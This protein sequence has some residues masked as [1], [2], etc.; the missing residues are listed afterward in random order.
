MTNWGFPLSLDIWLAG[1]AGGAY[2]AAF[3][4][5]YFGK[6]EDDRLIRTALYF[7]IPA[8]MAGVTILLID[9]S[10]PFRFWHLFTFFNFTSPMS[11]GS[12]VLVLW[13]G[14][15]LLILLLWHTRKWIRIKPD[16]LKKITNILNWIVFVASLVL[17]SYTGVLLSASSQPVWASTFLLPPLFVVSAVSTGAAVLIL[18]GLA[19]RMWKTYSGTIRTLVQIV[20]VIIGFEFI[21]LSVYFFLIT[22]SGIPG[23]VESISQII[24]GNLAV[25]FWIGVVLMAILV[26]FVVIVTTWGRQ[27]KQRKA[28]FVTST[29]SSICVMLGGL[30]LRAVIVIGGQL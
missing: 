1:M 6:H 9:L 23:A 10:F 26:P 29:I 19:T 11:V 25:I 20:A 27:F 8:A 30:V 16:S 3:L 2:L 5:K 24:S 12:W 18:L 17:I 28:I 7:A 21:I 22:R 14:C 13:S 15:S 4:A